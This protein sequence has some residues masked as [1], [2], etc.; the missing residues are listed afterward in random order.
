MRGQSTSEQNPAAAIVPQ[1]RS[2]APWRVTAVQA[3]P[4]FCL[5]VRFEDGLEGK[6]DLSALIHAPQAGVFAVLADPEIFASVSLELGA[7]SWPEGPDL[8][9]DA[10]HRAI[11]EAGVF[12]PE[13]VMTA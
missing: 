7:V 11:H 12:A 3:L 6:V 5:H 13:P 2:R 8:A 4:D 10:M 1:P 9:P